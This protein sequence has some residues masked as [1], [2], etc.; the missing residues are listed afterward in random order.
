M[1]IFGTMV[2][3]VLA[4]LMAVPLAFGIAFFLTELAPHWLRRPVGT[5]IELLAAVPSIIYGMWGFF[6][7]V[8]IMAQYVEPWIIDTLGDLPVVGDFF[9]QQQRV[10]IARALALEPRLL[11]FDE[12]TSSLDPELVGE[13]LD[14]IKDLAEQGTTMIVVTHEIGFARE[15]RRHRRVHGRR[16]DRR[17]GPAAPTNLD[18]PRHERTRAFLSR[19]C[20]AASRRRCRPA[21]RRRRRLLRSTSYG[22]RSVAGSTS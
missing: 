20:D 17:A 12:P 7:I 3:A 11:L 14:V 10:A 2:T 22:S 9:G 13:V 8:P 19:C 5:A 1:P 4:L 18:N 16:T 21:V 6:V 15:V